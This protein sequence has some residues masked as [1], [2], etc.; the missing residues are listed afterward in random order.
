MRSLPVLPVALVLVLVLVGCGSSSSK[1]S[2][3]ASS[4][5]ASTTASTAASP[6]QLAQAKFAAAAGLAF[7]TFNRYI[8][9]PMKE[10]K[11]KQPIDRAL[12]ATGTEAAQFVLRELR[13]ATAAAKK[14]PALSGVAPQVAVLSGGFSAALTRLK[15]GH[16]NPIEI[17]TAASAIES[18]KAASA[19]AGVRITEAVV[20]LH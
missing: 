8:D 19:A 6:A 1:S 3:S 5:A 18:I 17:D 20:P 7:G 11:L 4:A 14:S 9:A 16:F 10:G 15:A 12:L 2:H 13:L